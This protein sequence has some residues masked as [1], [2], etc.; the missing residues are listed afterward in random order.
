MR[1]LLIFLMKVSNFFTLFDFFAPKCEK[2]AKK[3][4][5]IVKRYFNF[6]VEIKEEII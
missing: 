1:I 2:S 5:V 3:L 4:Q 6:V